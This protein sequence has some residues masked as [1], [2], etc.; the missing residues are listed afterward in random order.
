[1]ARSIVSVL[2]GAVLAGF[3]VTGALAGVSP[4]VADPIPDVVTAQISTSVRVVYPHKDGFRD[5]VKIT[6]TALTADASVS[7]S[8]GTIVITKGSKV[9]K[10]WTI[11]AGA[12]K[13][14]IWDGRVKSKISSGTYVVTIT[15]TNADATTATTQATLGV[16]SKKLVTRH[17]SKTVTAESSNIACSLSC[18]SKQIVV[19][20]GP[21]THSGGITHFHYKWVTALDMWGG[22]TADDPKSVFAAFS[23]AVPSGVTATVKN[24]RE[25]I[26]GHPSLGGPHGR[27]FLL[28][29]CG[30]DSS[31]GFDS[32]ADAKT[33]K[34]SG[35]I[36]S[37]TASLPMGST[38]AHWVASVSTG[39]TAV[40]YTFTIHVSYYTLK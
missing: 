17:W 26:T 18:S 11:S 30:D 16:S 20:A 29:A 37:P 38:T 1:V 19:E 3:V 15:Y 33:I 22:S 12:P 13:T 14:E 2:V 25:Y 8:P 27:E 34:S 10:T 5:T 4:A 28:A 6:A 32:C 24:A 39:A 36:T 21:P 7:T 9:E 40:I 23:V 31:D 35:G